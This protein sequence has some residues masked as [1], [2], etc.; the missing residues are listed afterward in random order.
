[1]VNKLRVIT[2]IRCNVRRLHVVQRGET[3]DLQETDDIYRRYCPQHL[4]REEN[5]ALYFGVYSCG[6]FML[7]RNMRDVY[8][9][10]V[11]MFVQ[12]S[13]GDNETKCSVWVD[14]I[15]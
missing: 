11:G 3:A 13:T 1:M 9:E 8:A 5:G 2:Y 14:L 6:R 4:E 10:Y 12:G 7:P 15:K